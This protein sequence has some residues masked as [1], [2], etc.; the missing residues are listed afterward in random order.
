M[1][2]WRPSARRRT[3]G[4]L[5]MVPLAAFTVLA[6]VQGF[7]DDEAGWS[8]GLIAV[9]LA[10]NVVAVLANFREWVRL[11]DSEVLV[12][13]SFARLKRVPRETIREIRA[14]RRLVQLIGAD[15]S[16]I[17]TIDRGVYSDGQLREMAS[18]LAIPIRGP[19]RP[20][21]LGNFGATHDG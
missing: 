4:F 1:R 5:V 14:G 13:T 2:S 17:V 11:T 21:R 7:V 3:L 16:P 8:P 6:I 15:E 12:Q 9:L 19:R 20:R 18:A 10:L